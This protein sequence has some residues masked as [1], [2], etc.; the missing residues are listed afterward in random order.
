MD[1]E[2]IKIINRWRKI[3]AGIGAEAGVSMQQVY[4]QVSRS[5]VASLPFSQSHWV[6]QGEYFELLFL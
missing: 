3:E 4:T 5:V 2:A 6:S 1:T